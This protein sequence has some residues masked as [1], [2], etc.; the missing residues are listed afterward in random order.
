[1]VISPGHAGIGAA[2]RIKPILSALLVFVLAAPALA[3]ESDD[4]TTTRKFSGNEMLPH[5]GDLVQDDEAIKAGLCAGMIMT[6][7]WSQPAFSAQRKF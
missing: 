2:E 6:L 4:A 5:C 7:F 3:A 1:M